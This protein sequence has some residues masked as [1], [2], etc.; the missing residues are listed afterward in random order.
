MVN[1][2]GKEGGATRSLMEWRYYKSERAAKRGMT[3]DQRKGW[4]C[5]KIFHASTGSYYYKMVKPK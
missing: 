4:F 5:S 3:W 1:K 2:R